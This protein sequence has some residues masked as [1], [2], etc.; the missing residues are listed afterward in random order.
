MDILLDLGMGSI[1]WIKSA[2]LVAALIPIV[3][4]CI[5]YAKH[6][7]WSMFVV[8]LLMSIFMLLNMSNFFVDLLFR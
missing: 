2:L 6:K 3:A 1:N 7:C 4:F 5:A 8:T